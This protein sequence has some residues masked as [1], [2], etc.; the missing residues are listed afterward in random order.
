MN[1]DDLY[2]VEVT[3]IQGVS[4][5]MEVYRDRTLLIVNVASHCG[6]TP[7]YQ[8]L[9]ALWRRYR[10]RGLTVLGFPCNQFG[11]QEPGDGVAIQQ[12]CSTSYDVTFPIFAK[13]EVN[14][15]AAH[16]LF[17]LLKARRSG[18]LGT[19]SIK[20]NFTKFLVRRDGAVLQRFGPTDTPEAIEGEVAALLG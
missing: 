1:Q 10:D 8:G 16:P 5:R 4:Q 6:F 3:T 17:R 12:F 13:I 20:W 11:F 2:E 15:R 14:G 7:Q 19:R 18:W 9:E